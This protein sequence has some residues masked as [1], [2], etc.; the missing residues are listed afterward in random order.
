MRFLIVLK[1]SALC[2]IAAG[3]AAF[4][5]RL[6]SEVVPFILTQNAG[7]LDSPHE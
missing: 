1:I 5:R 3:C 4:I 7:R 2:R 6:Q